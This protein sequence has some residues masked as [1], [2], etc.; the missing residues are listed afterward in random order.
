MILGETHDAARYTGLKISFEHIPSTEDFA[1]LG[2][3]V[4]QVGH[5]EEAA[6]TTT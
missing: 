6:R 2:V 3:E 1:W 5:G 4:P